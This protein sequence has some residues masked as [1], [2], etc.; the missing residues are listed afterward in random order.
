MS[1][2]TL[3]STSATLRAQLHAE[4]PPGSQQS[5][6]AL[7]ALD[8]VDANIRFN[9]I[10]EHKARASALAQKDIATLS[11]AEQSAWLNVVR[12]QDAEAERLSNKAEAGADETPEKNG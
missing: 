11:P 5:D 1:T 9:D 12:A 6:A 3:L 2:A 10:E 4:L 8:L 7:A